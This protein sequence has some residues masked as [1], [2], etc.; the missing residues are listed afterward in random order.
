MAEKRGTSTSNFGVGKRESHDSSAFYERFTT[1]ELTTD[2]TIAE[3]A[4]RDKIWCG[5]ARDMDA[6]GDV[7]DSSVALVVTSPPYFAGKAYEESMG[8][9]HVPASYVEYLAMLRDVFRECKR[10]LQPGGRMAINVANLGRKPY[11]SL[12]AD[13]I[14]ILQ[15]DL[16]LL[17]RGEV[18]WRKAEGA[19][20]SCACGSF[21]SPSNPVL[22]DTSERV[23][24]AS[25]GR[26]DRAVSG[27]DRQDR[28]LPSA[29]TI[30]VDEFLDS[31]LDVWDHLYPESA[32]AV[33]H[34]APFPVGLP[35]RLIEL[36]T[37]KEELVLDPFMGAGSTAIAAVQTERYY[38]GFD[39]EQEYIDLAEKRI[40]RAE[41]EK[42]EGTARVPAV[43]LPVPPELEPSNDGE[44]FQSRSSS[45]G[46][47]ARQIA[48]E[49]L[50]HCGFTDIVED[51]KLRGLGVE[52]NF[53]ATSPAGEEWYFDVSGAFSSTRPG[54]RR[55]DT[56]WKALGKA[57]VIR[58][59]YDK[60]PLVFLTTDRPDPSSSGGKALAQVVGAGGVTMV[61]EMYDE[62]D[63]KRLIESA[64]TKLAS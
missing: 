24:V 58:Q 50:E 35:K 39:T 7:A 49:L 1:P 4:T 43:E 25:K 63:C 28:K 19:G 38:V 40:A 5:D 33:G 11:R 54:L 57:F 15:D 60:H 64:S 34:P 29:V 62:I 2:E 18:I 46:K 27:R 42:Q 8:E 52:V 51:K 44:G 23:I 16:Q 56:L 22:R 10:K 6:F 26:F 30:S 17:L 48:R 53:V 37:Y 3:I 45:E 32:T 55:T 36:Y 31:T 20:G 13:V 9:G 59:A 47:K 21:Q 14:R 61:V 12:S 41:R